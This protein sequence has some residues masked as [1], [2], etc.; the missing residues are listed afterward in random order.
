MR[1]ER[2]IRN[3]FKPK[4]PN[5]LTH[6]S[7]PAP[8]LDPG[9]SISGRHLGLILH[10]FSSGSFYTSHHLACCNIKLTKNG[11]IICICWTENL[12][13]KGLLWMP[14]PTIPGYALCPVSALLHFST[15]VWGS[16][17][18]LLFCLP[19]PSGIL[20]LTFSIFSA[21]YKHLSSAMGLDPQHF[22]P[23]IFC[24]GGATFACQ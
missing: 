13:H 18:A 1:I 8:A 3:W 9:P 22:S 19:T 2:F 12:P 14:L 23:H 16:P 17:S 21:S 4:T 24:L 5:H 6:T 10:S 11:E 7:P 20:P 15:L